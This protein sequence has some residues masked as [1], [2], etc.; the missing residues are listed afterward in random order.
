MEA[1]VFNQIIGKTAVKVINQGNEEF[2]M[3]FTDGSKI[4][5]YHAQDCCEI[6]EINDIC[7]DLNDL[8][9]S[10]L[11]IAE[12]VSNAGETPE[13]IYDEGQYYQSGHTWTFYKYATIKGS[14]TVRWLGKS[15]GC[16]SEKVSFEY[17]EPNSN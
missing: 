5:W 1:I 16:Y 12:E 14:V 10:P 7:G 2:V 17:K 8:I 9:D 11:L 15:N 6:V 13:V 4:T 3:E